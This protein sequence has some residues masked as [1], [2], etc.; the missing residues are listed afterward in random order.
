MPPSSLADGRRRAANRWVQ[1]FAG[2]ACM[3]M[4]TNLQYGWTLFVQPI[5]EKYGWGAPAIQ[6]AFSI[7][8]VTEAWLVPLEG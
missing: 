2:V 1:L 4:I 8:V 6:I 7:V 5:N 3:V